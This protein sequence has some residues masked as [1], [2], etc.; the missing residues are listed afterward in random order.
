MH[1]FVLACGVCTDGLIMLGA[2]FML[3][4]TAAFLI[5]AVPFGVPLSVYAKIRGVTLQLHPLRYLLYALGGVIVALPLTMGSVLLPMSV[6]LPIWLVR[7]WKSLRKGKSNEPEESRSAEK[8]EGCDKAPK[9]PLSSVQALALK[10]RRLAFAVC[11]GLVPV[12]YARLIFQAV[13]GDFPF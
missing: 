6:F 11:V 12:A 7:L 4:W 5:W 3:Y 8:S 9:A 2:P 13:R 10:G 1:V